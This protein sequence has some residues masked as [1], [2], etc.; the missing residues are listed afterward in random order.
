MTDRSFSA[1]RRRALAAGLGAG[2]L[3]AAGGV[4]ASAARAPT[5]PDGASDSDLI[6]LSPLRSD[7]TLSR[8]QAEVWFAR[9][10]QA[11]YVVTASDAW[12]ARAV[13]AGLDRAKVWIG[14]VGVWND[15]PEYVNL[16][17]VMTRASFVTDPSVHEQLLEVFGGKYRLE[18][19]IWGPR[20]R[21]GLEDGSR[22]MLR[23]ELA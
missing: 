10:D 22:V 16:P 13:T 12:R 5:L 19:L 6:Y 7:G 4:A 1:S 14:D 20:W 18:W 23:Y 3:L 2:S 17:S 15:N 8:C 9:V 21:N 11:L